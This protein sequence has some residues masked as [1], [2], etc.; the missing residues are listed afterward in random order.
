MSEAPQ[1]ESRAAEDRQ[2]RIN[3]QRLG[4]FSAA[5]GRSSFI[6]AMFWRTRS[7]VISCALNCSSLY[8]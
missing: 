8:F 7:E 3:D 5:P 6:L 1:V 4:E 2:S